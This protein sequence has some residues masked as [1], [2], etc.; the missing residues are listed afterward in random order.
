[1]KT[2]KLKKF[3]AGGAL[4]ILG[5]I[6]VPIHAN[7]MTPNRAK[8]C[9]SIQYGQTYEEEVYDSVGFDDHAVK[10]HFSLEHSGTVSF[11]INIPSDEKNVDFGLNIYTNQDKLIDQNRSFMSASGTKTYDIDLLGGDYTIIFFDGS[12]NGRGITN[13]SFNFKATYKDS[14]ETFEET[15]DK[16][17][18]SKDTANSI[19]YNAN[20]TGFVAIKNDV[21]D[22]YKFKMP[23]AGKY[24][25]KYKGNCNGQ[26]Q[27]NDIWGKV[28]YIVDATDNKTYSFIIPKGTYYLTFDAKYTGPYQFKTNRK[29]LTKTSLKSVTKDKKAKKIAIRWTRKADVTGYQIQI[30]NDKNFSKNAK[31]YT[32]EDFAAYRETIS[33]GKLNLGK[34]IY[35]RI[36][37]FTTIKEDD[38]TTRNIFSDWS[39]TVTK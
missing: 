2:S 14:K 3:I 27:L 18:N 12:N 5:M 33:Q 19:K 34:K 28:N 25:L 17:N 15:P 1:M 6:M 20:I 37:T 9:G 11:H 22:I 10:Y 26:I 30:A 36:R 4:G 23:K 16:N 38:K 39:S 32:I 7:A 13:T 21:P 35:V 31:K 24:V 29:E 8:D